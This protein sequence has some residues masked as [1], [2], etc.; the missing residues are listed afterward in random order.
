M[1]GKYCASRSRIRFEAPIW[2]FDVGGNHA[3]FLTAQNKMYLVV[4]RE[5]S[6]W[7]SN[8]A[9]YNVRVGLIYKFQNA[10]F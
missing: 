8:Y 5:D 2:Q 1:Q 6:E 9:V 3:A 4:T 7:C 10:N